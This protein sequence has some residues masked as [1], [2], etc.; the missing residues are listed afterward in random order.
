MTRN[1]LKP[2]SGHWSHRLDVIQMA[3]VGGIPERRLVAI[4]H[5]FS[6]I[7]TQLAPPRLRPF[8]A[9]VA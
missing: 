4:R 1:F 9:A 5:Q 8:P 3:A 6:D 7:P 2:E